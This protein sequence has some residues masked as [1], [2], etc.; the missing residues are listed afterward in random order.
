MR[1]CSETICRD[2]NRKTFEDE[3]V[4]RYRQKMCCDIYKNSL[5]TTSR[6]SSVKFFEE[7]LE[8]IRRKTL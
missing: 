4:G 2:I 8:G 7:I 6:A 1:I 5:R 3:V